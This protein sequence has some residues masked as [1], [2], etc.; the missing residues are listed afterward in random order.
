MRDI[1]LSS[2]GEHLVLILIATIIYIP[3]W[4]RKWRAKKAQKKQARDKAYFV[5]RVIGRS[6]KDPLNDSSDGIRWGYKNEGLSMTCYGQRYGVKIEAVNNGKD[7][8]RI[9]VKDLDDREVIMTK[10]VSAL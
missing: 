4:W 3:V 1:D 7:Q 2:G 6:D 9:Y 5:G 8:F 10:S